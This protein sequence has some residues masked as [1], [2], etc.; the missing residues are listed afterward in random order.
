MPDKTIEFLHLF[1]K[2]TRMITS[3]L[4]VEKVLD[5][6]VQK[7][8][9]IIDV[10]AATIRLLDPAGE[11]LLLVA[12]CG[13]SQEYLNRGPID[14]EQSVSKALRGTP[15]AIYD[16]L[17]Y[18]HIQYPEAIQKEGIK[19]LLIAPVIMQNKVAGVLRLLIKK[20][21][22]FKNSEIEFIAALA[23]CAGQHH[24]GCPPAGRSSGPPPRHGL[25]ASC[26]PG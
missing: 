24:P 5:L 25:V 20:P 10:D 2:V 3:T 1:Q 14:A 13:L 4:N 9:E 26:W 23:E 21:R 11:K 6:I 17:S 12:S 22:Q 7:V 8:P 16:A 15:V 19:S 18:P